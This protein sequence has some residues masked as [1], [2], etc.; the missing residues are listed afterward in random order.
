MMLTMSR[1]RPDWTSSH[2]PKP[3]VIQAYSPLKMLN[4]MSPG[5][6]TFSKCDKRSASKETDSK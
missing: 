5:V 1:K 4:Y 3:S 2:R 6:F